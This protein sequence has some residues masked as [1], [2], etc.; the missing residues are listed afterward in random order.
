VRGIAA[1]GGTNPGYP[2]ID[3]TWQYDA[4][5]RSWWVLSSA[6]A[7]GRL[8]LTVTA[9][10]GGSQ[11]T[12]ECCPWP[13]PIA[14]NGTPARG[15]EQQR[16]DDALRVRPVP[17]SGCSPSI[18]K[19]RYMTLAPAIAYMRRSGL[20]SHRQTDRRESRRRRPTAVVTT[21]QLFEDPRYRL[22]RDTMYVGA[23]SELVR[24]DPAPASGVKLMGC[25]WRSLDSHD[26]VRPD[27]IC[28][29]AVGSSCNLCDERDSLRAALTQLT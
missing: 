4:D 13:H 25:P 16:S 24:F 12:S 18:C 26:R 19:L 28:T 7:D 9:I 27:G 8:L 17:R 3:V 6:K 29:V 23:E 14:C 22:S 10:I 1:N 21:S 2:Q 15:Q 11:C 20:R 5:P